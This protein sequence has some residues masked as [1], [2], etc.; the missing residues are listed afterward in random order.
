MTSSQFRLLS[1]A[2]AASL[3]G[4]MASQAEDSDSIDDQFVGDGK[5]DSGIS[6][7]S[8]EAVAVL[9]LVNFASFQVLDDTI[10]L[11]VRA[12]HNI[13]NFR[14]GDDDTAGTDDDETFTTLAE[15]DAIPYIGPVAFDKLV[16]FSQSIDWASRHRDL[17]DGSV[18][19]Q[20]TGWVWHKATTG[21]ATWYVAT[22]YGGTVGLCESST[23]GGRTWRVPT[24]GDLLSLV[25]KDHFPSFNPIYE[26][27][28]P[29]RSYWTRQIEPDFSH[30]FT[31][32]F[33]GGFVSAEWPSRT[34]N[35][36]CIAT[37]I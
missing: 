11:D 13:I 24:R 12:A 21:P 35:V 30:A 26:R 9:R 15:L 2:C 33:A 3:V 31:V 18:L 25:D 22:G 5:T 37:D 4:C 14:S 28:T 7:D 34:H 20:Y 16:A 8:P 19:D 27:T 36:R 1:A 29:M 17:G 10:G 6:E 32:D 23:I